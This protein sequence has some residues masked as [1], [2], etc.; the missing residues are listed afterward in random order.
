MAGS[1]DQDRIL[2]R[3]TDKGNMP[4]DPDQLVRETWQMAYDT[5]QLMEQVATKV[6]EHRI[7]LFGKGADTG[8]TGRIETHGSRIR[9][10]EFNCEQCRRD[11]AVQINSEVAKINSSISSIRISILKWVILFVSNGALSSGI[12]AFVSNYTG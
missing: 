12:A 11:I 8:L 2:R 10:I 7:T 5:K 4:E 6:T 1:S 9:D 3:K